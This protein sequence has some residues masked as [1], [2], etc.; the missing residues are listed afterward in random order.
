LAPGNAPIP[1]IP[2]KKSFEI[3]LERADPVE[4]LGALSVF[5]IDIAPVALRQ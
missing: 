2:L 5:L 1:D 4:S 3:D